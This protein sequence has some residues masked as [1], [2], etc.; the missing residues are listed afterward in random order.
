MTASLRELQFMQWLKDEGYTDIKPI[1]NKQWAAI[2]R[3]AFTHSIETGRIF[4]HINVNECF[5]YP[6][7]RDAKDALDAWD[8]TGEPD[9]WIRSPGTGRRRSQSPDEKDKDGKPVG[10]VGVIYIR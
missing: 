3:K 6:T 4:D 8:G 7:Y 5:C 9:K 10:A 1:P 2:K